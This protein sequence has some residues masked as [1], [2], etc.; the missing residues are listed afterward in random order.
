M[1]VFAAFAIEAYVNLFGDTFLPD[2]Y[3]NKYL[4]RLPL[5]KRFS[6]SIEM[7]FGRVVDAGSE[8][9]QTIA[10]I[11]KERDALAHD[12]GKRIS[13]VAEFHKEQEKRKAKAGS[14]DVLLGIV[15]LDNYVSELRSDINF[16]D[17]TTRDR[18]ASWMKGRHL[19][20]EGDLPYATAGFP[21]LH[22]YTRFVQR[23]TG[24]SPR[25]LS[26]NHECDTIQ[27][28]IETSAVG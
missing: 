16:L 13:T 28:G 12:K 7:G 25:R 5:I 8:P 2:G 18:I 1:K 19:T 27:S 23:H 14:D 20:V 22:E 9:F 10:K 3:Y 21:S 4:D 26:I 11:M 17:D 24:L 6:A 15:L